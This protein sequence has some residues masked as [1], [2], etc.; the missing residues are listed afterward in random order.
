M[1]T[2]KRKHVAFDFGGRM[3]DSFEFV[4]LT[5]EIAPS[6]RFKDNPNVGNGPSKIRRSPSQQHSSGA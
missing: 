5:K 3:Q 2:D 4:R 1:V 6:G